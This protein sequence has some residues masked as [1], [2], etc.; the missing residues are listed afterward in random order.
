MLKQIL[1]QG[2]KFIDG[3][4]DT[5]TGGC[6]FTD[7]IDSD[8]IRK[9]VIKFNDTGDYTIMV[10]VQSGP[11]AGDYDTV[12]ITVS[13]KGVKFDL[14]STVVIGEKL[15]ITGIANTGTYV[16]VFVADVCMPSWMIL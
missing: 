4:E 3:V 10:T 13:E 8:G 2:A 5:L 12:D 15:D 14:P 16:D 7:T 6:T 11:R 9:Y 1:A